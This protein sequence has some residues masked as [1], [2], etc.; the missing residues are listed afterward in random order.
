MRTLC[1]FLSLLILFAP[2]SVFSE[3]VTKI[4]VRLDKLHCEACGETI[5]KALEPS[6][7]V[8]AIKV[9]LRRKVVILGFPEG[10]VPDENELRKLIDSVGYKV[11][12]IS[13]I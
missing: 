11:I 12:D 5:K 8:L 3:S 2:A 7:S 9:E 4:A 1:L 10:E 13:E 6:T